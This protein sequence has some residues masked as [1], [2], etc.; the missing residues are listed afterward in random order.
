M[1][2][3]ES[4]VVKV[5]NSRMVLLPYTAVRQLNA[6]ITT[7]FLQRIVMTHHSP[8]VSV[9]FWHIGFLLWDFSLLA[10][11]QRKREALIH[12]ATIW[13]FK[14]QLHVK[15]NFG[16]V[17]GFCSLNLVVK[18][19]FFVNLLTKARKLTFSFG[20]VTWGHVLD[21][22]SS[23][24]DRVTERSMESEGKHGKIVVVLTSFWT[25]VFLFSNCCRK[26]LIMG[27]WSTHSSS[28]LCNPSS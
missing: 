1:T 22:T 17:V 9:S 21:V 16:Y 23:D 26:K 12:C 28:F 27:W 13:P 7:Y 15:M 8:F 20:V 3:F 24:R 14:G 25:R 18:V 2:Q 11:V 10:I 19:F 4:A 6:L 5:L